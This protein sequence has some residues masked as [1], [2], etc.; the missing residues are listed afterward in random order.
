M[1]TGRE[2]LGSIESAIGKLYR[3]ETQLDRSL[4]SAVGEAERLRKE[5]AETLRELARVKLDEMAAG[6]LVDN[7]DAG[8]RRAVQVLDE[9]RRRVAHVSERRETLL[10]E[11]AD[12]RAE[13]DAAAKEVEEKLADVETLRAE[14]ETR[15]QT[16]DAWQ[17]AKAVSDD[18]NAVAGE[19]EK[20]AANSEAELG[21]KK[22]PYDDDPLF[23]YLWQRGFGTQRY[24]SNNLVRL[25][26][27]MVADFIDFGNVRPNYAALIE[28]PL[29]L[30]EHATAKR[31]AAAERLAALSNIERRAMVEAGIEPKEEALTEARRRLAA[32]DATLEE[33]MRQ[34]N[35]VDAER[36]QLVAGGTN[37]AYEQALSVIAAA[38]AKDQIAALYLEVKRTA[39]LSDDTIVKKLETIDGQ[40]AKTD[41]E[42]ADLRNTAK[43]LAKRRVEIERVRDRFRGAGYDHPHGT[44]GNDSDIADALGRTMAGTIAGQVLWEILQ[45]GYATRGPMGRPDFGYPTFPF[46]FPI[47]GGGSN[48]PWGG[49]WRDPGSHGNWF[50]NGGGDFGG[51]GGG[52]DF[53]T[54]G[55]FLVS[56]EHEQDRGRRRRNGGRA[57]G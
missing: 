51:G 42:V 43:D 1:W 21:A 26:D 12:A 31:A 9:Y 8:E 24:Q 50:P 35:E 44:F 25:M 3:E 30:R 5:R 49:E 18:A 22:K 27:R 38:D 15:V 33:K 32:A 39:L 14:V 2:T 34:L 19:A 13:R 53:S 40:I 45:G 48:G 6:R 4:R 56:Q 7:L 47:P 52:G 10:K 46:P 23:I 37:Q 41:A 28:I 11:A 17:Q 57:R 36:D 55:S 54:G 20:K 29:R 16:E